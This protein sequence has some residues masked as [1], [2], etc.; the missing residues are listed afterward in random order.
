MQLRQRLYRLSAEGY[1]LFAE[2]YFRLRRD[3]NHTFGTAPHLLVYS[4]RQIVTAIAQSLTCDPIKSGRSVFAITNP[5]LQLAEQA[6]SAAAV[7]AGALRRPPLLE[8][9]QAV[10]NFAPRP[11]QSVKVTLLPALLPVG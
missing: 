10:A 9:I 4:R 2:Q 6:T 3:W 11:S 7:V 8:S 5:S 1:R